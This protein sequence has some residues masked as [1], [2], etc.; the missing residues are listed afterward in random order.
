MQVCTGLEA[1]CALP[2]SFLVSKVTFSTLLERWGR[3]WLCV[4]PRRD[5]GNPTPP[6]YF[7]SNFL[8][9]LGNA[10]V[11]GR[12]G[13]FMPNTGPSALFSFPKGKW[14]SSPTLRAI[15]APLSLLHRYSS[16]FGVLLP[17]CWLGLCGLHY[18]HISSDCSKGSLPLFHFLYDGRSLP[19]SPA[20]P[21]MASSLKT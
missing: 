17:G 7:R 10:K 5:L 21:T 8:L 6:C 18:S 11:S 12:S 3:L 13:D 16:L 2:G 15:H 19:F 9:P 14:D 20:P 1:T 4:C